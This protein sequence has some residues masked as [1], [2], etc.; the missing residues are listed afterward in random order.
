MKIFTKGLVAVFIASQFAGVAVAGAMES[1]RMMAVKEAGADPARMETVALLKSSEQLVHTALVPVTLHDA[2][3]KKLAVADRMA[4]FTSLLKG[5]VASLTFDGSGS[6]PVT[7]VTVLKEKDTPTVSAYPNPS[8]GVTTL[9]LSQAGSDNYKIRISNTIGKV[10]R[11]IDLKDL[12]ESSE[13]TLDLSHLPA[14]IYFY[15]LLVNEKMT[16]TKRL[17]LQR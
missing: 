9:S 1:N 3:A 11:T 17:V 6:Q 5:A 16:E 4:K 15:S 10:V 7:A 13:V 8:R 2:P 14:G 12:N